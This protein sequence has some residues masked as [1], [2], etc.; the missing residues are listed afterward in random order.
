MHKFVRKKLRIKTY[1]CVYGLGLQGGDTTSLS[2][3]MLSPTVSLGQARRQPMGFVSRHQL[4]KTND[5]I[6][7]RTGM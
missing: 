6:L 7:L 2:P 4:A 5:R 3:A 1:V